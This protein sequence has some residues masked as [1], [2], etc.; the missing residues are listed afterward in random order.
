MSHDH[1]LQASA[2]GT[3]LPH[4]PRRQGW[5]GNRKEVQPQ[6][7]EQV[8]EARR[9][10]A[11]TSPGECFLIVKW[12]FAK[13]YTDAPH[14]YFIRQDY[15]EVFASLAE[16]IRKDGVKEQFTL[17]G[18]TRWYKYLYLED[19]KYW[20]IQNVMNRCKVVPEPSPQQ[21]LAL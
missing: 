10:P 20:T 17:R 4:L 18:K 12:T 11:K 8:G 9:P 6:A 2:P 13:T 21:K 3:Y 19:Y 16:L 15:P 7:A 14:E 5:Q 1:V